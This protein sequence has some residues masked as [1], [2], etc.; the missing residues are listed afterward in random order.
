M[1]KLL[2]CNVQRTFVERFCFWMRFAVLT[3]QDFILKM[4]RLLKRNKAQSDKE[5]LCKVNGP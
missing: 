1:S 5:S 2:L 4:I 3:N